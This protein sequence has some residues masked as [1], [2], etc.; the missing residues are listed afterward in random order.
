[1]DKIKY[2]GKS[3]DKQKQ[4][5]RI[6]DKGCP[7]QTDIKPSSFEQLHEHEREA[8]NDMMQTKEC[9]ICIPSADM[10]EKVV[11]IG[12]C[13]GREIDKF[14]EFS[15]T[16]FEGTSAKAPLICECIAG[17]ECRVIDYIEKY[18]LVILECNQLWVDKTK[19]FLPTLHA[20]MYVNDLEA[21]REFLDRKSVV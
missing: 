17:L 18:G 6:L 8:E 15:L 2:M 7:V 12:T 16:P 10:A 5:C 3:E 14:T 11:G 1:M 19:E 21:E 13:S 20:A 4:S 9:G